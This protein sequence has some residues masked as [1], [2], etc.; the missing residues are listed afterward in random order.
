MIG[1]IGAFFTTPAIPT[2]YAGLSKPK[3]VP[4]DAL[5]GP[6]WILLFILIGIS[7]FFILEHGIDKKR[8]QT[9]AILIFAAQMVLNIFW[10]ILFFGLKS[11]LLGL[12]DIILLD[13]AV[14][15]MIIEYY[16]IRK[17][18]A[19]LLIPYVF[20]ILFATYLNFSI[21]MLN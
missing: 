12:I 1:S 14:I 13:I 9:K 3:F 6:V 15:Y 2:W 11:P 5:F 8:M 7:L 17:E 10:S 16:K 18:A 20:W 21:L 4:P 19:Y